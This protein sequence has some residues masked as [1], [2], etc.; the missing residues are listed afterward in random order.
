MIARH[1]HMFGFAYPLLAAA[2]SPMIV[3]LRRRPCCTAEL[4]A[5]E[6]L[7][8]YCLYRCAPLSERR[9]EEKAPSS[10]LLISHRRWRGW[11]CAARL[12]FLFSVVCDH[13]CVP[14]KPSSQS[15]MYN[16]WGKNGWM[17]S[18]CLKGLSLHIHLHLI[19]VICLSD[20]K[21]N[22]NVSSQEKRAKRN[23]TCHVRWHACWGYMMCSCGVVVKGL[24][25]QK[26]T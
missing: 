22:Q 13:V 23:I 21:K 6:L 2:H 9:G 10:W 24:C 5:S 15:S 25:W 20:G 17:E 4:L 18:C 26:M 1:A 8:P 14:A 7:V 16:I 19:H 12:Y 3:S 11:I